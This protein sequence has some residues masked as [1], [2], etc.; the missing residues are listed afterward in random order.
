MVEK[1]KELARRYPRFG[2]RRLHQMLVREGSGGR[3]NL[4]R[5]RRLCVLAGLKLPSRRK[6]KRRGK[7]VKSPVVAEHPNHVWAYDFVFDWCENGRQLKFL[8]VEDEFT[9]ECLAIEVDHR[10]G[11]GRVC[12]VLLGLMKER[13]VPGYVRSDNG[14]EF[15]AKALKRMLAVKGVACTHIDP[16]SPWQNGRNERF[17]GI[18]R[19]ECLNMETFHH[20]DHARALSGLFRRYYN[21]ERPHSSL[22]YRTPGEFALRH[23]MGAAV[24]VVSDS[25]VPQPAAPMGCRSV[26]DTLSL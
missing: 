20:R 6:R 25:K 3:V 4:K 22:G 1:L 12:S 5:V 7:G 2:Y 23:P 17:N 15:V 10:M 8:T 11:A 14:P 9:R 18:F 21:Q 24:C 19:D 26:C 16:G 13:G